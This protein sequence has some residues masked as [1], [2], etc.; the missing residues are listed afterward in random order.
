MSLTYE[1]SGDLLRYTVHGDVDY[2]TGLGVLIAGLTEVAETRNGVATPVLFDIT[3]SA[4]SRS[5]DELRGIATV[6]G[7]YSGAVGGK[8]AVVAS[9]GLYYGVSR[10]FASFIEELG[11]HMQIFETVAQAERWLTSDD[12]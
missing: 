11:V 1:I 9:S 12:G 7:Q 5:A 8:C 2:D 3:D 10:M 6:V 4:E